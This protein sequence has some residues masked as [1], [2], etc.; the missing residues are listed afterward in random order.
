MIGRLAGKIVEDTAEGTLVLDVNGVGY[1]VTVPLGTVGRAAPDDAG[2][3]TLFIHTHVREDALLLYGFASLDERAAFK[4][5]IS[6][7]SIGPKIA[8]GIL[9]AMSVADLGAAIARAETARLTKISGV[10]KKTAERI[11]LELKDRILA[12]T[13]TQAAIQARPAAPTAKG[14][15]LHG[16]L[17]RMG[18]RPAE[19]ERAVTALGAR[20]ETAPLGELVRD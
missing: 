15:L 2:R 10:G 7:A 16:A 9:G 5:L 18:F 20:V 3:V 1:E 19:A 6:V 13:A 12:P 11:V 4:H 8:M 17:T 14:E